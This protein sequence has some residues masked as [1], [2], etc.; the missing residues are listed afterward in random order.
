MFN[1]F[2]YNF[3]CGKYIDMELLFYLN[4]LLICFKYNKGLCFNII[5]IKKKNLGILNW[6]KLI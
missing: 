6:N 3:I 1:K 2:V 5:K 4:I